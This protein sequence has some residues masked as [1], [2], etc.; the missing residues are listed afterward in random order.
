MY[1]GGGLYIE[2]DHVGHH[3]DSET[4]HIFK[5]KAT[6][7]FFNVANN[8]G[9]VCLSNSRDTDTIFLDTNFTWNNA[10][11]GGALKIQDGGVNIIDCSFVD[12]KAR[13]AGGAL[14]VSLHYGTPRP[15][16]V[17][18][19]IFKH[20]IVEGNGSHISVDYWKE[21]Y[22]TRIE[23]AGC[24]FEGGRAKRGGAV[25]IGTQGGL[26]DMGTTILLHIRNWSIHNNRADFAS[27]VYMEAMLFYRWRVITTIDCTHFFNNTQQVLKDFQ[28]ANAVVYLNH[29]KGFVSNSTFI[30]N[31][32]S[33]ISADLSVIT[34][35][36][37][38]NFT[39][40][41]AYAGAAL[42]LNCHYYPG[43]LS[44]LIFSPRTTVII[45]NNTAQSYSG[46]IAVNPVCDYAYTCF[47]QAP[48][49]VNAVVFLR[50]N[51]A[52]F[53]GNSIYGSTINTCSTPDH[54]MMGFDALTK[55]FH[56]EEGY[57]SDQVVIVT[58]FY[59]GFYLHIGC[60]I[61]EHFPG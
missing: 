52:Q 53:G 28:H 2:N 49:L 13:Q 22:T 50:G 21:R 26:Y 45:A 58:R 48:P 29:I 33:C 57:V 12:N 55:V 3:R 37:K 54:R 32:G 10:S 30:D 39:H 24:I 16:V 9:G 18:D 47:F 60:S 42:F 59:S 61:P 15:L 41:V 44:R 38:V 19:T 7:F 20:N 5:I 1:N 31:T 8:G 35:Q 46:G 51:V 6:H 23:I 14:S 27:A 25:D 36:G 17:Q 43:Q 4:N 11:K 40:N 34:L 56:V